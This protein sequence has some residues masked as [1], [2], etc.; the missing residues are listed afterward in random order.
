MSAWE[1]WLRRPQKVWTRR[2]LFQVHLWTGIGAGVYIFLISVSGSAI[3]FRPELLRYFKREAPIVAHSSERMTEEALKN[4]A[5]QAFPGHQVTEFW[6]SKNPDAAVEV[7]LKRGGS[8]RQR[9]F[10]PYTG[11][12][13]GDAVTHGERVVM[14]LIS[15]HDNLL[16]GDTGRTVNGFGALSLL[17]LCATGVVIW[18]PGVKTWRRSLGLHRN[19]NWQRFNWHLHSAIGF[20][21]FA[22]VLMWAVTGASLAFPRLSASLVD[23][24]EPVD[25]ATAFPRWGDW[26]L[27]WFGR[28]HFGRFWGRPLKVLWVVLGLLPPLLFV[29][30]ALMWWSRVVRPRLRR[31]VARG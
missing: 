11:E 22:L 25:E 28:L 1:E 12:D 8:T 6:A 30:G 21:T 27:G 3:V 7:W 9:L 26:L 23:Y 16:Y 13:L 10:D 15:F 17:L 24:F 29:T 20:W 14:G 18:W 31:F 4:S 19:L 5:Q 2:V